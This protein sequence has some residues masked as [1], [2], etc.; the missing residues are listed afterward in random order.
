MLTKLN[1]VYLSVCTSHFTAVFQ[2]DSKK[3]ALLLTWSLAKFL[4]CQ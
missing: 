4:T 2:Q 1:E 3:S